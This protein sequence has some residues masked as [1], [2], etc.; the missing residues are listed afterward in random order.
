MLKYPFAMFKAPNKCITVAHIF[1]GKIR[2]HISCELSAEQKINLKC[3]ALFFLK[4]KKK[5]KKF[6]MSS[7][8]DVISTLRVDTVANLI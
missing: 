1:S 2:L 3:Q 6:W 5:K 4:K 7:A 8:A